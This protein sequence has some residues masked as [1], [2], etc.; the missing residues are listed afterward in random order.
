MN[1]NSDSEIS[2]EPIGDS[3]VP[4]GY[5]AS[6]QIQ[7]NRLSSNSKINFQDLGELAD[8]IKRDPLLMRQLAERVYQLMVEDLRQQK[9]RSQNYRGLF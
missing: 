7:T 2:W 5:T 3:S 8:Q 6:A 9:E 4:P 1:L